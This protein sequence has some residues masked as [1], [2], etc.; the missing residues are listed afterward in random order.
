MA[1]RLGCRFQLVFLQAWHSTTGHWVS[2]SLAFAM[3][4]SPCDSVL[5]TPTLPHFALPTCYVHS[6]VSLPAKSVGLVG[7]ARYLPYIVLWT[8]FIPPF[9]GARR[10]ASCPTAP[11]RSNLA[12][13]SVACCR[14]QNLGLSH[15]ATLPSLLPD[16]DKVRASQHLSLVLTL[17][18]ASSRV[19]CLRRTAT[20]CRTSGCW[21]TSHQRQRLGSVGCS[22]ETAAN[23]LCTGFALPSQS[24]KRQN[25]CSYQQQNPSDNENGR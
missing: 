4:A 25:H 20:S 14:L 9:H 3:S 22:V 24:L 1:L 21:V 5:A 6:P 17:H 10:T 15:H 8:R 2:G 16:L 12:W 11:Y 19:A 13:P 23:C 7:L 18:R